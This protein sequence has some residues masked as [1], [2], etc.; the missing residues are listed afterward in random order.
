MSLLDFYRKVQAGEVEVPPAPDGDVADVNPANRRA[1][2][3]AVQEPDEQDVIEV[4]SPDY[5][6]GALDAAANLDAQGRD[7]PERAQDREFVRRVADL[8]KTMDAGNAAKAQ[9]MAS[10]PTGIQYV[11]PSAR[12]PVA[13]PV[14]PAA[15]GA[16]PKLPAGSDSRVATGGN[17]PLPAVTPQ[18]SNFLTSASSPV[19][20]AAPAVPPRELPRQDLVD[21][22]GRAQQRVAAQSTPEED[23]IAN[24]H[25]DVKTATEAIDT[26]VDGQSMTLYRRQKDN[27]LVDKGGRV[28]SPKQIGM[29][30]DAWSVGGKND[31]ATVKGALAAQQDAYEMQ[32][33]QDVANIMEDKL[34]TGKKL[35]AADIRRELAA[36]SIDYVQPIPIAKI[37]ELA[38]VNNYRK[39]E[40]TWEL[41]ESDPQ[42]W[43]KPTAPKL[44]TAEKMRLEN[45]IRTEAVRQHNGEELPASIIKGV[46]ELFPYAMQMLATQGLA[47]PVRA[48]AKKA[49]APIEG[50]I[51]KKVGI[52][53]TEKGLGKVAAKD[54]AT[55]TTGQK[56]KTVGKAAAVDLGRAAVAAPRVLATEATIGAGRA[57]TIGAGNVAVGTMERM[58]PKNSFTEDDKGQLQKH[59][60]AQG[61]DVGDALW[62][63]Y[64]SEAMGFMTEEAGGYMAKLTPNVRKQVVRAG[65]MRAF[66]KNNPNK[67]IPDFVKTLNRAGRH[68]LPSEFGEEQLNRIGNEIMGVDLSE[69]EKAA[70]LSERARR[71][72]WKDM[73]EFLTEAAV[74]GIVGVPGAVSQAREDQRQGKRISA[75]QTYRENAPLPDRQMARASEILKLDPATLTYR[76]KPTDS[77]RDRVHDMADQMAED[78]PLRAHMLRQVASM[79]PEMAAKAG[80]GLDQIERFAEQRRDTLLDK[81]DKGPLNRAEKFELEWIIRHSN[82]P[83]LVGKLYG[84]NLNP[85]AYE[86]MAKEEARRR[87]RSAG[88][89]RTVEEG[90]AQQAAKEA[91]AAHDT[92]LQEYEAAR[93]DRD[94]ARKAVSEALPGRDRDAALK[95]A[96]DATDAM[97]SAR[98][99]YRDAANRAEDAKDAVSSAT[100]LSATAKNRPSIDE[101]TNRTLEAIRIIK[102]PEVADL[103]KIADIHPTAFERRNKLL[104]LAVQHGA[105]EKEAGREIGALSDDQVNAL[106]GESLAVSEAKAKDRGF[107][108]AD[109]REARI[110]AERE[111]YQRTKADKAEAAKSAEQ[112][113][114]DEAERQ[115]TIAETARVE[116]EAAA[117]KVRE[118]SERQAQAAAAERER[119]RVAQE[120]K[121]KTAAEQAERVRLA[122]TARAR[123]LLTS[124]AAQSRGR[125]SM[126]W[127]KANLGGNAPGDQDIEDLLAEMELSGA[128]G[129]RN[130][131]G[132]HPINTPAEW[133][134]SGTSSFLGGKTDA[135][136]QHVAGS[137]HAE[138]I[139]TE[140]Y[141]YA[142][143]DQTGKRLGVASDR[144]VAK[145]I[146]AKV[147]SPGAAGKP[148]ADRVATL[149]EDEM[150]EVSTPVAS[151]LAAGEDLTEFETAVGERAGLVEK[152][153]ETPPAAP[154]TPPVA[155]NDQLVKAHEINTPAALE[156]DAAVAKAEAAHNEADREHA[157]TPGNMVTLGRKNATLKAI[158]AARGRRDSVRQ[159][160][161]AT[162]NAKV[163]KGRWD[164][165]SQKD[166]QGIIYN[167]ILIGNEHRYRSDDE[168]PEYSYLR[169]FIGK[170]VEHLRSIIERFAAEGHAR[171]TNLDDI[172][173]RGKKAEAPPTKSG[174][175]AAAA[176]TDPNPSEA[177]RKAGNYPKG[178]ATI[179]G[180]T[181]AVETPAGAKRKPEFPAL[182]DHYG[183]IL[184]TE[185]KDGDPVDVFVKPGTPDDYNGP[186]F[187]VEQHKQDGKFDEHKTIIG[188]ASEDEARELYLRNYSPGW[189][190]M[191]NVEQMSMD[192]FKEWANSD[193][194][195]KA[196]AAPK[197][198]EPSQQVPETVWHG[199]RGVEFDKFDMS[200]AQ[201]GAHFFS[202]APSH[203]AHF[204]PARPYHVSIKNP[205]VISQDDLETAWDKEHPD[206]N[207]DDRNLLPRDMVAGFVK[208]AKA[209]GH[210][211]LIVRQMADLD[212]QYDVFLPFTSEQITPAEQSDDDRLTE[213]ATATLI[214]RLGGKTAVEASVEELN[215]AIAETERSIASLKKALTARDREGSRAIAR[216]EL[217][218]E[219]AVLE[220]VKAEAKRRQMESAPSLVA[221]LQKRFIGRDDEFWGI[222]YNEESG[223]STFKTGYSGVQC[224]GFACAIKHMLEKGRV[225]VMGWSEEENPTSEVAQSA[226]G[227]DIAVVDGRYI[228]DP[229]LTD[230]ESGEITTHTGKSINVNG[231][232]VFDLQNPADAEMIKRLYGDQSK[233]KEVPTP[234]AEVAPAPKQKKKKRS[235]PGYKDGTGYTPVI[236]FI[237]GNIG[238]MRPRSKTKDPGGEYDGAP[239]M[240]S[241][242]GFAR[243]IYGGETTGP[244][245]AA[246]ALYDDGLI[247]SPDPDV[248]WAAINSEIASYRRS[249]QDDADFVQQEK[250]EAAW[251]KS[252]SELIDATTL[253]QGDSFTIKGEVFT[254]IEETDTALKIKDGSEF[255]VPYD[256]NGAESEMRIDK[257]SLTHAGAAPIG[258][259]TDINIVGL[260]KALQARFDSITDNR[261]LKVAIGYIYGIPV[262]ELTQE[263][264][265]SHKHAQEAY[266]MALAREAR[267]IVQEAAGDQDAA[268]KGLKKLYGRQV[269]LGERTSKSMGNQAYSTPPPYGYL[270]GLFAGIDAPG[271]TVQ[272]TTAGNGMLEVARSDDATLILNDL[273]PERAAGLR[274]LVDPFNDTVTNTDAADVPVTGPEA[275]SVVENP[276]FGKTDEV[277]F[278]GYKLTKKE[279]IIIARALARMKPGGRAAFI[280]GGGL[281]DDQPVSGAERV[282]F[283]WLYHHYNV[284][285][286][287]D[288][289]GGVYSKQGT[290]FNTR[291]IVVHGRKAAPAGVAPFAT[292]K[293][294]YK[295]TLDQIFAA[296][297]EDYANGLL[298]RPEDHEKRAGVSNADRTGKPKGE[299]PGAKL[300]RPGGPPI[301]DNGDADTSGAGGGG[302]DARNRGRGPSGAPGGGV[303]RPGDAGGG[304]GG[305]ADQRGTGP[306]TTG[307]EAPGGSGPGSPERGPGGDAETPEDGRGDAGTGGGAG[308]G[309]RRAPPGPGGEPENTGDRQPDTGDTIDPAL[310]DSLDDILGGVDFNENQDTES[311]GGGE[312][313]GFAMPTGGAV[314]PKLLMTAIKAGNALVAAGKTRFMDWAR[315]L[316]ERVGDAILPY[317]PNAYFEVWKK[318][319]AS[320]RDKFDDPRTV[321][322][323]TPEVIKSAL[324]N[325]SK[326][327]ENQIAERKRQEAERQ[328]QDRRAQEIEKRK[329]KLAEE[330]SDTKVRYEPVSKGPPGGTLIPFNLFQYTRDSLLELQKAHGGDLDKWVADELGIDSVERLHKAFFAEQIDAIAAAIHNNMA[331]AAVVIGDQTGTGKGRIAA[332]MLFWYMRKGKIPVFVTAN[333]DLL[334]D[335][336]RDII[337]IAGPLGLEVPTPWI[338][339]NDGVVMDPATDGKEALFKKTAA[340][341][342]QFREFTG[343][344]NADASFLKGRGIVVMTYSQIQNPSSGRKAAFVR[345][346]LEKGAV[347]LDEAHMASGEESNTGDIFRSRIDPNHED[348][349]PVADFVTY[350][351]ATFA[352][353][354]DN[355]GLYI[356]TVLG[357]QQIDYEE[358]VNTLT[359]AG[360]PLQEWM[361]E[362]V[363][364]AGQ[365]YRRELDFS[366]V[367]FGFEHPYGHMSDED[368]KRAADK[369]EQQM[370]TVGGALQRVWDFDDQLAG[371][372]RQAIKD[373]IIAATG[374]NMDKG[375]KDRFKVE[376]TGFGSIVHHILGQ[377]LLASRVEGVVASTLKHLRFHDPETKRAARMDENRKWRWLQARD[378]DQKVQNVVVNEKGDSVLERS[379]RR[380]TG[381]ASWVLG[382]L[383]E[384]P[385]KLAPSSKVVVTVYNTMERIAEDLGLKAGSRIPENKFLLSVRRTLNSIMKFSYTDGQGEKQ[386]IYL[387]SNGKTLEIEVP[388]PDGGT[389]TVDI[390]FPEYAKELADIDKMFNETELAFP[391][392][393]IDNIRDALEA[394]GLKV[395]EATGRDFKVVN[396]ILTPRT[397]EEKRTRGVIDGFNRGDYDVVI[398]NESI[399]TGVS[400]HSSVRAKDKR[401]RVMLAA[402]AHPDINKQVQIFGRVNRAG[403]VNDPE[404]YVMTSD[405]PAEKRPTAILMKKMKLLNANV[406]AKGE[407]GYMLAVDDIF[408]KYGDAVVWNY[409]NAIAMN[410]GDLTDLI[411]I[412]LDDSGT[413][414]AWDIPDSARRATGRIATI[415]VSMQREF[416]TGV[417]PLYKAKIEELNQRGENDLVST[418]VDLQAEVVKTVPAIRLHLGDDQTNGLT[419]DTVLET[420]EVNNLNRPLSAKEVTELVQK[421]SGA[422]ARALKVVLT[423]VPRLMQ[424]AATKEA[425]WSNKRGRPWFKNRMAA[426]GTQKASKWAR[427]MEGLRHTLGII[428]MVKIGTAY[429][430]E[431]GSIAEGKHETSAI[432]IDVKINP[433][434]ENPA[435]PSAI[436][437]VFAVNDARKTISVPLSQIT[438]LMTSLDYREQ[439]RLE[440]AGVPNP[441]GEASVIETREVM[442]AWDKNRGVERVQIQIITGNLLQGVL[443]LNEQEIK[444]SIITFTTKDGRMVRG[445]RM[446]PNKKINQPRDTTITKAILLR[447]IGG[448]YVKAFNSGPWRVVIDDDKLEIKIDAVG[449]AKKLVTDT[450]LLSILRGDGMRKVGSSGYVGFADTDNL[451]PLIDWLESQVGSFEISAGDIPDDFRRDSPGD[452]GIRGQRI[453]ALETKPVRPARAQ[454]FTTAGAAPLK[455]TGGVPGKPTKAEVIRDSERQPIGTNMDQ[456]T[457]DDPAYRFRLEMP[458]LAHLMKLLGM[459]MPEIVERVARHPTFLGVF[460]SGSMKTVTAGTIKLIAR[461]SKDPDLAAKVMAHEMGHMLDWLPHMQGGIPRGNILGRIASLLNYGKGFL[462]TLPAAA[463]LGTTVPQK[464]RDR[465]RAEAT[466]EAKDLFKTAG[467]DPTNEQLKMVLEPIFLEKLTAFALSKGIV[468][469]TEI[470]NELKNLTMW[471]NPWDRAKST[472]YNKYRD[473]SVE[474]YAEAMSVMMNAPEELKRRAPRFYEAY[475][476][477]MERKPLVK[478]AYDQI[479]ASLKSGE[480]MTTRI[481]DVLDMFTS[482]RQAEAELSVEALN[483]TTIGTRLREGYQMLA[484]VAD[485]LA[486]AMRTYGGANW[487]RQ[488]NPLYE[489]YRMAYTNSILH[490]YRL[491]LNDTVQLP[492]AAIDFG[493]KR[494]D[495]RAVN[496][497][498]IFGAFLFFRRVSEGDRRLLFNPGGFQ[499]A[500]GIKTLEAFEAAIGPAN[501]AKL[502]DLQRALFRAR[503]EYVM[504]F[505]EKSGAFGQVLPGTTKTLMEYLSENENY[506]TFDVTKFMQMAMGEE[507]MGDGAGHVFKQTGT[508]S[509]IRNPY[510]ATVLNDLSLIHAAIRNTAKRGL[511]EW[512]QANAPHGTEWLEAEYKIEKIPG[513]DAV[514]RIPKDPRQANKLYVGPIS[515]KWKLITYTENGQAK[516]YYLPAAVVDLYE[517]KPI[518]QGLLWST[519]SMLAQPFRDLYAGKN[520]GFMAWNAQRD[521]WNTIK[522]T[523]ELG[524]VTGPL[525]LAYYYARS[526]R[527]AW[528]FAVNGKPTPRVNAMLKKQMLNVGM[529]GFSQEYGLARWIKR[530]KAGQEMRTDDQL[531]EVERMFAK[532]G[533][534]QAR[535][536]GIGGPIVGAATKLWSIV[537]APLRGISNIGTFVEALPKIAG[538]R[539]LTER[540]KLSE[541]EII[542]R[543]LT[544]I[545]S[546]NFRDGGSI[547]H[548]TNS[549]FLFSNPQIVGWRAAAKSAKDDP[550]DY[551]IK[552]FLY[553]IVPKLMVVGAYNGWLDDILA[554]LHGAA[555]WMPGLEEYDSVTSKKRNMRRAGPLQTVMAGVSEYDLS[556]R[557]VVPL[558]LNK[559]GASQYL[560]FPLDFGGELV[561][562][563]LF[564]LGRS[565]RSE[566]YGDFGKFLK[567]NN[568]YSNLHPMAKIV[569]AWAQYS[570]GDNPWD[571][572]RSDRVLPPEIAKGYFGFPFRN[573]AATK[574]MAQWSWNNVLSTSVYRMPEINEIQPAPDGWIERGLRTPVIQPILRRFY[575]VSNKGL[576]DAA[577]NDP[578]LLKAN[579]DE[580]LQSANRVVFIVDHI[581]DNV[582][583]KTT[584]GKLTNLR[585]EAW[586]EAKKRGLV[587]ESYSRRYFN[588]A[589]DKRVINTY[590]TVAE[591]MKIRFNKEELKIL[592]DG[593]Q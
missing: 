500:T 54:L 380:L 82:N 486:R 292:I 320:A 120:A 202:A 299:T 403:Q 12:M 491:K 391:L 463:G 552:V 49:M 364:R 255:W 169:N 162:H 351:S 107:E 352:K 378:N 336:Y 436:E 451:S 201:D 73:D 117:E 300:P 196:K 230:V 393:P 212:S 548:I 74:L 556:R 1:P 119:Q 223:G 437:L 418:H 138:V 342:K 31:G 88:E 445:I 496:N 30:P 105:D 401:R 94:A 145:A 286:N 525:Q 208:K 358:L 355:M 290:S 237:A 28:L 83:A 425:P 184:R 175:D 324:L 129:P 468:T 442:R 550:W 369:L 560:V 453:E 123:A 564:E 565:I 322:G 288:V 77:Q 585:D 198:V 240:A 174:I 98:Q 563:G 349:R 316:H 323:L 5:H 84:V 46:A 203:A 24:T 568:P 542:H 354:P 357:K 476:N 136:G 248:M 465:M 519:M 205:M 151:K 254:V 52:D 477:W 113:A 275:D 409:L 417:L 452:S 131:Q 197:E 97:D 517:R 39:R 377:V 397:A 218:L 103:P 71:T 583:R 540:T 125:V 327:M 257:G 372:V 104:E 265:Y 551:A 44:S 455:N 482:G 311:A 181:I 353:R 144:E 346:L 210:D 149:T 225:K 263:K 454:G 199:S 186:V 367:H 543:V 589:Y 558:G 449:N 239:D 245:Q 112:R 99:K 267:R 489:Y 515:D 7:R 270:L 411:R 189:T 387:K 302:T 446:P 427:T 335:I 376:H 374:G 528:L 11:P 25:P 529:M 510:G 280:I 473:S 440:K 220:M 462:E 92:A 6:R 68:S 481:D 339:N 467:V 308:G 584:E 350:L 55:K 531:A 89:P 246:Q 478:E 545:G 441:A 161:A 262:A 233:W 562:T 156:A 285:H 365:L 593:Q 532:E 87:G 278:N 37:T 385:A 150:L 277:V 214:D 472:K 284:L 19:M 213:A 47:A 207:Q 165:L 553:N 412:R 321:R 527:D 460:Y 431:V 546:P 341:N 283:N 192:D 269:T 108:P 227:H 179:A 114:A 14:T 222:T 238:G 154:P 259:I 470:E 57:A 159:K 485:P 147:L 514:R 256:A 334:S 312:G 488:D 48:A 152:K 471:W 121:D 124:A 317:L 301:S 166:A 577:Y 469:K 332:A 582:T 244:D 348:G 167:N 303:P 443:K 261:T 200:K 23:L 389:M 228:V 128:V 505:L 458:E 536:R 592:S 392:S 566:R 13:K 576:M 343:D 504:P 375:A 373:A 243:V 91:Q 574:Q 533:I 507:F 135:K 586:S 76:G 146:A 573:Q 8:K 59:V 62:N 35:D 464:E 509:D 51:L 221:E 157:K 231:R 18:R 498:D 253:H 432:L 502:Y 430:F 155:M 360:V 506:A 61:Q 523:P 487:E 79:H 423:A 521:F 295:T 588:Q 396:G 148:M 217:E 307:G 475:F 251:L 384:D 438:G 274:D 572:F 85:T 359:T 173:A 590:G 557:I 75:A 363:A 338:V 345:G 10:T 309:E 235:F 264:G 17:A 494:L 479:Q 118:E 522:Q 281:R 537:T 420:W 32:N 229:W 153:A 294:R 273:D 501:S 541:A 22:A 419:A 140:D 575:R 474:L 168:R 381:D 587:P 580:G 518:A 400:M 127:V 109:V 163:L 250:E 298:V 111:E 356:R 132:D 326:E 435:R 368:R 93:A 101:A 306:S 456:R 503:T 293:T 178:R 361:A 142:I 190:G 325:D 158:E 224:T 484:S 314:D 36:H 133:R 289:A 9:T 362:E 176:E 422:V 258:T 331:G 395:A 490:G 413:R 424:A 81:G 429:N 194:P 247:D 276:P 493:I 297:K 383:V 444:P 41:Y 170:P 4:N 398:G 407:G 524:K 415:P 526:L 287:F 188:A 69:E 304:A 33:L 211:G 177:Q 236:D 347:V 388:Q 40:M 570:W 366:G 126:A 559:N 260:A 516:G 171:G 495:G 394:S 428:R 115:K 466:R 56:L 569:S 58:L 232:G 371:P 234:E 390:G 426:G 53:A 95:D 2:A 172:M 386:T 544:R 508:L 16:L 43:K 402:Q 448:G 370:D 319:P 27:A 160:D 242:G 581:R 3:T 547:R 100:K 195:R 110:Q 106:F 271:V 141:D 193:A 86:Q 416:W 80:V 63:S 70:P 480:F 42:K 180:M 66:L 296:L 406:T 34:R 139:E 310:N 340:E 20:P 241:L 26:T 459:A 249:R 379:G 591:R 216:S 535:D 252:G 268:Y 282:F 433:E 549:V 538:Y 408:N 191:G 65:L 318:Q 279:H 204:G 497:E 513:K 492:L 555:P 329:K 215:K 116:R 571:S 187:I 483:G 272:D 78:E 461:L 50:A 164:N 530:W 499:E 578:K 219:N 567:S 137:H 183:H 96:E 72:L 185:G 333:K 90:M 447:L 512:F 534:A 315:I 421:N 554:W 206:G 382:D 143:A 209:A 130:E 266:E 29:N 539:F 67:R 122:N 330:G 457:I 405:L 561:T 579:A 404:L 337:D 60:D 520:L 414:I 15:P 134:D 182:K 450:G 511:V 344:Y 399:S 226:G 305:N 45:Y 410:G 102:T 38:L 439:R 21:V 313:F 434:A 328:E 291:L 64:A